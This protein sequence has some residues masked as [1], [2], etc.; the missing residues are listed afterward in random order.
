[1]D[2]QVNSSV[3]SPSKYIHDDLSNI[4]TKNS[5]GALND[6]VISSVFGFEE[7]SSHV[8]KGVHVVECDTD[9]EVD[10]YIEFE[11]PNT[12]TSNRKEASTSSVDVPHV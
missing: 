8:N 10:E 6:D 11:N 12:D 2:N 4:V 1:M 9:N 7:D 5:F 3:S